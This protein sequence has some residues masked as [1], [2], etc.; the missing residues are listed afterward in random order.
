MIYTLYE[1]QIRIHD[2][3]N[4]SSP[5]ISLRLTEFFSHA[6]TKSAVSKPIRITTASAERVLGFRFLDQLSTIPSVY[7][8][9]RPRARWFGR[10]SQA[11]FP[12]DDFFELS[13]LPCPASHEASSHWEAA[14]KRPA[15]LLWRN[16]GHCTYQPYQIYAHV[17]TCMYPCIDLLMYRCTY[18]PMY[19][20]RHACRQAFMCVSKYLL[21]I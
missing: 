16:R 13:L 19:A 1:Y 4:T 14:P 20:C 5:C 8:S 18:V 2:K 10:P 15:E 3:A 17:Y 21:C 11:D 7:P 9:R 6:M 12:T